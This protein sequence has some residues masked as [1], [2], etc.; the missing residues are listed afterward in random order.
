MNH[1]GVARYRVETYIAFSDLIIVEE[2]WIY[3]HKYQKNQ[4]KLNHLRKLTI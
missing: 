4:K 1:E 3:I 2:L